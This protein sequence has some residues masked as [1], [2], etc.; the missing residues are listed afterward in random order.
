MNQMLWNIYQLMQN[1]MI[2][3]FNMSVNGKLACPPVWI[4][5]E[6]PTPVHRVAIQS[7]CWGRQILIPLIFFQ[8]KLPLHWTKRAGT[9]SNRALTTSVSH[10]Y[11]Y[12]ICNLKIQVI[13]SNFC[14]IKRNCAKP[15]HILKSLSLLRY[16]LKVSQPTLVPF[17]IFKFQ[18]ILSYLLSTQPV[19][20]KFTSSDST[21]YWFNS[22]IYSPFC[23]FNQ[24]TSLSNVL[25]PYHLL[26][27][28]VI[29]PKNVEQNM[30]I[31]KTAPHN[32]YACWITY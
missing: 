22:H 23:V 21:L 3:T 10:T 14:H 13:A 12:R 31:I 6:K 28:R 9:H 4:G 2:Y 24:I 29:Y 20:T 11:K 1:T 5:H 32:L 16:N 17:H 15:V 30:Q 19:Y 8:I 18:F 26:P 27:A 7:F 25:S